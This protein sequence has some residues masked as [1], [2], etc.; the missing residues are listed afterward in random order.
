MDRFGS[1]V[2]FVLYFGLGIL[3]FAATLSGIESWLGLHWLIAIPVSLFI[4]YLPFVGTI[5]G[6][7]GAIQAWGWE[8]YWAV[9]LFFGWMGLTFVLA[10]GA[11]FAEYIQDRRAKKAA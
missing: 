9:L 7:L 4:G 11:M 3:Q 10:S 6:L 1:V 8:W 2:G 5:F